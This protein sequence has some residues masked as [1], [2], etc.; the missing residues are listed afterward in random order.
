MTF[1]DL[2]AFFTKGR[3]SDDKDEDFVGGDYKMFYYN[4]YD[5]EDDHS[6]DDDDV[7]TTL[8][9]DHVDRH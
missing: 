5:E 8:R 6:D 9:D 1:N 3:D 2:R 4:N 7:I